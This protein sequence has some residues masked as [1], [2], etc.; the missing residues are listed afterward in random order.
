M[1]IVYSL[2]IPVLSFLLQTYPRF[3][4]RHFGVDVWTRLLEADHIR[5]NN[6]RI[7]TEKLSDQFIIGGYFD[8]P[9]FFPWLL[10]FIPKQLLTDLQGVVSPFFDTLQVLLIFFVSYYLT[11]NLWL[12]VLAQVMYMLTPMIALENS[13]LTPRSLGYLNLS[14]AIL[15]LLMYHYNGQLVFFLVGLFF[16]TTL[17][18]THRFALQSF[19]FFT[20]FSVFYFQST[21]FIQA[22]L[23]GFFAALLITKGYYLRVLKGHLYNIYFWTQNLDFRFAHQVRGVMKKETKTDWVGQ[24]YSFLSVFSPIAVFGLDP[25]AL[26]AFVYAGARYLHILPGQPLYD[27]LAAWVI[28][29]YV[30]GVV[31]LKVK[32]LMPIGEGQR[33][34]E[35]STVPSSFLAAYLFFQLLSTSY[36]LAAQILLAVLLV[37]NFALILIVQV[38]GV[39]QDRNRSITNDMTKV[40]DFINAQKKQMRIICVPHQNTTMTVYK[41]SA[42]VFVNADNEGL[43]NIQEVYPVLTKSLKELA[44]KYKLT[45]ALIKT[46]FTSLAELKLKSKQ[47]VFESGDVL[48]VKLS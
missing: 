47:I 37:G 42:A 33:Y 46:G 43:M 26:S 23:I 13:Y 5:K 8:Y 30:L 1:F 14:L 11:Q 7:P 9:P 3:F 48:L 36:S 40:F 2:I 21:E 24:V 19:F 38:K 4:N 34:M 35:M 28:F 45:H 29:F 22:L 15:P 25:W 10:S 17:F 32:K 16:T 31:V 41:T 20:L 39:I 12:S 44:T 27:G 6:H 18:L